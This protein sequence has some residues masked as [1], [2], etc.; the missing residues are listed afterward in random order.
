[1]TTAV[2]ELFETANFRDLHVRLVGIDD[3]AAADSLR[4]SGFGE[5][6]GDHAWLDPA[7]LQAGGDDTSEWRAGFA[8]M[9]DFAAKR[10]W[11]NEDSTRVRAHLVRS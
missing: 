6:D 4:A 7:A 9:L 2:V 1:M 8:A 3:N 5:L 11:T 10:G